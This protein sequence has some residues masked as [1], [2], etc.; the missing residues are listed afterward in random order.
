MG[1]AQEQ[2]GISVSGSGTV[3]GAPDRALFQAGVSIADADVSAATEEANRVT[4]QI[5]DALT[6]AGVEARDVRTTNFSV[7][8]EDRW[9]QDGTPQAPLYRVTNTANVTVREVGSVGDLLGLVLQN[10]ANQVN[11]VSF[12]HSDPASLEKQARELAVA[13]ALE[14]A[15]QLAELTGVT[16]GA[17]LSINENPATAPPMPLAARV[18]YAEAADASVPVAAGEL[19]V[20]VTVFINYAIG[21]AAPQ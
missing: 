4:Q 12:T 11:N 10:G 6:S 5:L 16:L 17:P 9:A 13:D 2:A 3:Y 14:R 20:T 15:S 1:L 19:G 21:G 8:R 18:A 7:W